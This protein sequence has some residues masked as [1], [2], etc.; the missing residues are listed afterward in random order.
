MVDELYLNNAVKTH[1]HKGSGVGYQPALSEYKD[2]A[3]E[4]PTSTEGRRPPASLLLESV[5][6]PTRP[7]RQC[8][9]GLPAG[10]CSPL[11]WIGPGL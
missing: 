5:T 4:G 9:H 8:S 3:W 6:P 7:S 2:P 10:P 1:T 11:E